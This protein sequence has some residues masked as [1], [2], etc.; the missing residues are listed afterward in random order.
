[1][2]QLRLSG[3]L[4]GVKGAFDIEGQHVIVTESLGSETALRIRYGLC[5]DHQFKIGFCLTMSKNQSRQRVQP[6]PKGLPISE[7]GDP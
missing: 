3:L 6:R 2:S 7:S 5:A 4:D 1:M